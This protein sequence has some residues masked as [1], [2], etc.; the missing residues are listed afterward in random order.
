M[1]N[2]QNRSWRE[3]ALISLVAWTTACGT[4][5]QG[6]AARQQPTSQ[7]GAFPE[8]AIEI[9][10]EDRNSSQTDENERRAQW[11]SRAQVNCADPEKCSPSVGMLMVG[12]D[13][14]RVSRCTSVLVEPDLIVTNSHCIPEAWRVPGFRVPQY[15]SK[16]AFALAGDH[17]REIVDIVQVIRASPLTKNNA[18]GDQDYAILKLSR[19]VERPPVQVDSNGAPSDGKFTVIKINPNLESLDG[20][21]QVTECRN[22]RNSIYNYSRLDRK[23][24]TFFLHRCGI[25]SGNS[26]SPIFASNGKVVGIAQ[27]KVDKISVE[28]LKSIGYEIDF[29]EKKHDVGAG[30]S[31]QCIPSVTDRR[32]QLIKSEGC[33]SHS[34]EADIERVETYL[35]ELAL[36][37][38]IPDLTVDEI[39]EYV[40]KSYLIQPLPTPED[41]RFTFVIQTV[42][43]AR[44]DRLLGGLQLDFTLK[45]RLFLSEALE[46]R[47]ESQVQDF[48]MGDRGEITVCQ[49]GTIQSGS[50]VA[51]S[52]RR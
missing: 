45:S 48:K 10:D 24:L 29:D 25:V 22:A 51:A 20:D 12:S 38:S 11:M 31:Y 32:T 15:M 8:A 42:C 47:A 1:L 43:A 37:K 34:F 2:N 4:K 39:R 7:M 26:G 13:N 30:S 21:M 3:I 52:R 9:R 46:V 44:A 17:P 27:A 41:R 19:A 35:R 33:V 50:A 36:L 5:V 23:P 14:N 28:S 6:P 49:P 18:I 16:V 40:W